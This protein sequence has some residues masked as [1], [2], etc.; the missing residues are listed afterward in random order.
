[1]AKP[2]ARI[3][4]RRPPRRHPDPVDAE[5][6]HDAVERLGRLLLE[7]VGERAPRRGEGHVDDEGV[8]LVVPR[9]VV[10]EAEIDHVDPELGIHDVLESFLDLVEPFGSECGDHGV[11]ATGAS[12]R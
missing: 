3:M 5:G 11:Y 8:V 1:M 9:E 6:V 12:E 7:H 2:R 4:S 10:D